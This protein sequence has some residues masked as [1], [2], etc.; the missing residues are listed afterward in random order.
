MGMQ[1][2]TVQAVGTHSCVLAPH[3]KHELSTSGDGKYGRMF[4]DL[5]CNE[6]DDDALAAL[7]RSGAIMDAAL[8]SPEEEARTDNPRIPAGFAVFGQFIAHNITADRSLLRHHASLAE[9]HNF[10]TP[11]LN[12]ESMYSAGP[13]DSPYIFDADDPDKFLLGLDDAGQPN[14]LPRNAQGVAL[15]GDPRDD[16]HLLIAQLHVV[17]LKFHNAVVDWLRKQNMPAEAVFAE[18]QRLVR[19]HYQWIVV[20]EFLPLTVGEETY[21]DV[22]ENGRRFY[23]YDSRPFIPVEFSDGA[24]RFG[25]SQMRSRY[26]IND[27]VS[28]PIFPDLAGGKP[29]AH[30][31]VLDWRYFFDLD[32]AHPPQPSKRIDGRLA[33]SLIE[34]PRSVV[35]VTTM[36]EE[37]SLAYRDL[38]RARSL[39][40]PSGEAVARAIGAE[41]LTREEAG[42]AAV[43]WFGETPLWYYVLREAEARSG[44]ERLGPV[45]GRIVA[46]VLIG[47]LDGDPTSYRGADPAWQPV[48]PAARPGTFTIS[49]LMRFAG[50]NGA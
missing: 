13:I 32:P 20:H 44:G 17:F 19:W 46:E 48:L 21:R 2:A 10:R 26:R 33:H 45:G 40:L 37:A 30:D 7:G 6:C 23:D 36:P 4:A 31:H 18:A 38:L 24:Y 1:I 42:M 47:L 49:D 12:L 43:G 41:P 27:A 29:L 8:L 25:H 9:I 34:L 5:P 11:S 22:L 16:V 50:A 14:D 39:D 28:G 3:L 35:G 15:L